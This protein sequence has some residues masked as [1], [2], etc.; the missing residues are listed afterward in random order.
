MRKKIGNRREKI[1]KN[2]EGT[3]GPRR[4]S[5]VSSIF[6]FLFSTSFRS[7]RG[8]SAPLGALLAALAILLVGAVYDVYAV[9]HYRTWAY[10]ATGEAA[11]A[12]LVAESSWDWAAFHAT[13]E[14]TLNPIAARQRAGAF[15]SDEI[16]RAGVS[17]AVYDVRV[18]TGAAGGT[19][20]GFPPV[21][22]ANLAGGDMTLTAPGVGVYLAFP[23]ET[24]WLG[25]IQRQ[26][27]LV[28][29]FSSAQ[30]DIVP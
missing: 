3:G 8:S 18:I 27:Y 26:E 28:H 1:E 16:A 29:A 30:T 11:R 21:S 20:P 25:L 9:Y 7:D 6:Y 23:V 17:G 5:L 2:R 12:A 10:E 14:L 22:H 19:V 15:L 13:G 24:A 4:A